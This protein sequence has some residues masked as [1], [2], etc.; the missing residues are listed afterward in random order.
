MRRC[1]NPIFQYCKGA[2]AAWNCAGIAARMAVP[3]SPTPVRELKSNEPLLLAWAN[4][5][6]TCGGTPAADPRFRVLA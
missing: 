5:S 2:T 4:P 1:Y 3:R 6:S